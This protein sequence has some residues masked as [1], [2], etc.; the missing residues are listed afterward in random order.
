L[1]LLRTQAPWLA[2][3]GEMQGDMALDPKLRLAAMPNA[4]LDGAANL[5][6]FPNLDAANISYGLLKTAAGGGMTIGPILLGT[7]RPVHIMTPQTT[8]RGLFDMTALTVAEVK[9]KA[10]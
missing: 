8:V 10:L 3:E 1:G 7:A 4:I 5:L 6:V 9:V 2:I